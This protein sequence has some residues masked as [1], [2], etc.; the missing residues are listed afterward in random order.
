MA[1]TDNIVGRAK[2]DLQKAEIA[3]QKARETL[4]RA[5]SEV[6]D[7]QAF[8]R[9]YQR[10]AD[11]PSAD[12]SREQSV[13]PYKA[14]RTSGRGKEMV[15]VAISVIR[16]RG[17]PVMI[18]DLLDS[19]LAAGFTLG[20]ADQKSNLAGYLSRDPRVHSVGRG[21]GWDLVESEEAASVPASDDAASSEQ[22]GGTDDRSTLTSSGPDD[23][24]YLL[25]PPGS[26]VP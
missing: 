6:A 15:D 9:T 17:K 26:Q 1:V 12:Q 11:E 5:E 3:A 24:N 13:N 8:L 22:K 21:I 25:K 10:Y 16:E 18:G 19:V 14:T 7:L 20:G 23:F 4:A 2:S